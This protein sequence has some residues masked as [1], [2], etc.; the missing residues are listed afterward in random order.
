[1]CDQAVFVGADGRFVAT[2]FARGPWDPGAQHGGAPAALLMRAL[3]RLPA[4][5]GLTVCRV[6]YEFLR[7]V[8]LGE[9]EVRSSVVRPGRRVQL[10]DASLLAGGVELIRARALQVQTAQLRAPRNAVTAPPPGPEQGAE[11]DLQPPYRP[12]FSL[13]AIELRF[14]AGTWHG[15]GPATAWFRMRIPL[16]AGEDASALQRLAAA[17]D[18]GNGISS[19]LSWHEYL[20]INPDLTLY[21]ERPPVGEWI[22]LEAETRIVDGGIGI[23]DGV[24]YDERGRVGRATQA[25]LVAPR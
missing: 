16:V 6:T 23:S 10:L 9:L 20:Y 8:P 14:V 1:M 12:M 19:S 7:P 21:I 3:E 22:G 24:L 11:N 2:D 4:S 5:E 18:F 17:G 25:L 13:D 15:E